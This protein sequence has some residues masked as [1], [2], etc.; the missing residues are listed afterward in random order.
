MPDPR[1]R[2]GFGL[3]AG[4]LKPNRGHPLSR[5]R[6]SRARTCRLAPAE[7]RRQKDP[8][9]Q[10]CHKCH[11]MVG[12]LGSLGSLVSLQAGIGLPRIPALGSLG[13]LPPTWQPSTLAPLVTIPAFAPNREDG[14]L[15]GSRLAPWHLGALTPVL[16]SRA[17]RPWRLARLGI[18]LVLAILPGSLVRLAGPAAP[19]RRPPAQTD[20]APPPGPGSQR[21]PAAT[22]SPPPWRRGAVL[23]SA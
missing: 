8:S 6:P 9:R 19:A 18:L 14:Q 20:K 17:P 21:H 22:W 7:L 16:A 3:Q 2:V 4:N 12:S 10:K 5:L 1:P 23:Q 15:Y 13:S 11:N